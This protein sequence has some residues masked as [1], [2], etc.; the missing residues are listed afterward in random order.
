ML[1]NSLFWT[2]KAIGIRIPCII[3]FLHIF[4]NLVRQL[5]HMGNCER[6]ILYPWVFFYTF[7]MIKKGL[8]SFFVMLQNNFENITTSILTSR[9]PSKKKFLAEKNKWIYVLMNDFKFFNSQMCF[10]TNNFIQLCSCTCW[11]ALSLIFR[12]GTQL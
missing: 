9:G 8:I 6:L 3:C 10:K 1:A 5:F 7:F 4:D 2:S 12:I 11:N